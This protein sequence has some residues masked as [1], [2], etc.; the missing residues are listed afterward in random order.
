MVYYQDNYGY[1]VPVM[2]TLPLEDGIAKATLSLMVQSSENDMQ[3]ARLGLRTVIPQNAKIDLDIASGK[4]R[5]DL[6]EE[7][8]NVADAAA[9]SNMI[10][11]IVQTLTEFDS[12][13][14][15]EF[16]FGGQK[17]EKL[18]Y[19]T[20][21]SGAFTRGGH[22]PRNRAAFQPPHPARRAR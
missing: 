7:A 8:L 10:H 9:E 22:Q 5:I 21:V 2:C 14:S 3:A 1:L 17:L 19:G 12:V 13:K 6:S 15:V 18:K 4:A 16:L 20:D 11:A